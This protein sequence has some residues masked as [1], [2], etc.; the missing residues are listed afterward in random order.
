MKVRD[1][2]TSEI[3]SVDKG[4][5]VSRAAQI[6][7]ETNIGV[8]SVHDGENVVG[9]LTDRDIAI[10]N[11]ALENSVNVPCEEAMTAD[12]ISC[13]PENSVEEAA[14]I[15]AKYQVRRLPVI[16][17]GKLVGMVALGDLAT[18]NQTKDEAGQTL[19]Q[20]STPSRPDLS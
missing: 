11:V 8:L 7:R 16:E 1:V 10:R 4:E 13:S 20:V 2:M 5:N 6:M 12:V 18:E 17:N 15:M 9:M 3:F 19:S 14:D